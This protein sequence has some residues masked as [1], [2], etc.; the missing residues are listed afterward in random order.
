MP[1]EAEL[2]AKVAELA[3]RLDVP[4]VAVGVAMGQEMHVAFHGVTN[5]DEPLP[6][7][8]GT[9]FQIGSTG[10]TY[11]ATAIMQLVEQGRVELD[12]PVR[13]YVPELHLKDEQVARDVTVLHLLNH[14][15]GWDGDFFKDTGEGPDALDLFMHAMADLDQVTPLG[16]MVSYNNASLGLAGLVIERVTGEPYEEVVRRRVLEPLGLEHTTF[17]REIIV[18]HRYAN[19]H[20]RA[21]DGSTTVGQLWEPGRYGLPQGAVISSDVADQLA[22]ARFHMGDG[23]APDGTRILSRESLEQMRAATADCAGS[24]LGDA[25]GISWLLR[26]IG[27]AR[28]VSHG[29]ETAGQL[30]CFETVPERAFAMTSLTNCGPVGDAFNDEIM[31]WTFASYLGL[32]MR[33]P[34]PLSLPADALAEYVGTYD[35]VAV[36]YTLELKAEGLMMSYV[37]DPAALAELGEEAT[38][39]P[40]EPIGILPGDG[41]RCIVT[42]GSAKGMRGYFSRGASGRVTGMHVGGRYA[43]RAED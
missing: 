1:P 34:E 22:W 21:Q 14:T 20:Y 41:D 38:D 42:G 8:A 7:D 18:T 13:T 11:T 36:V 35:T 33:D 24:A 5:L 6:V 2:Q 27:D 26:D 23:T 43:T 10:K 31:R 12:A 40:P 4:G 37:E 32:D 3:T 28:V 16:S 30:S 17:D 29:G 9:L 15:A 25:V 19:G 39:E